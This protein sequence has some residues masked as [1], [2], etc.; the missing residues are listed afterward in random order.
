MKNQ[1]ELLLEYKEINHTTVDYDTNLGIIDFFHKQ[2]C[3]NSNEEALV[4]NKKRLTYKELDLC[5]NKVAHC[6]RKNGIQEG[7]SV[8]IILSDK[9][10]FVISLLGIVKLNASY[11]P[12]DVDYPVERIRFM[13]EDSKS[14]C[15]ICDQEILEKNLDFT[16]IKYDETKLEEDTKTYTKSCPDIGMDVMYTSGT[17]GKP[18]GVMLPQ[19]GTIR[20]CIQNNFYQFKEHDRLLG[21]N[22]VIFDVSV[23][24]IWSALLNGLTL[25]LTDKQEVLEVNR[26][27]EFLRENKINVMIMSTSLFTELVRQDA[28]AFQ[29][30]DT[31]L[32]AGDTL[33]PHT[34]KLLYEA[35]K[36]VQLLNG[37]GPTENST[38]STCYVVKRED[39]NSETIPIGVPISRS[40]I[41]V[42]DENNQLQERNVRGELCVGGVGVAKEYKNRP[43]LSDKKFMYLPFLEDTIYKT[44]DSAAIDAD[45]NVLFYGR[46]DNQVKIRGFRVEL[47][48]IRN[49]MLEHSCIENVIV[50][51]EMDATNNKIICAYYV[52]S[53]ILDPHILRGY[54]KEK[55]PIYSIPNYFYQLE[56]FPLKIN[57]K[58][59]TEQLKASK[60]QAINRRKTED[61]QELSDTEQVI[62]TIFKEIFSRE[63]LL[64]EDDFFL[65]GGNS[66][67]IGQII[68][69][70]RKSL[71]VEV[72]VSTFYNNS[73][74]RKLATYIDL[75]KQ[76][77]V[78]EAIGKYEKSE[79]YLLSPAQLRIYHAICQE[80]ESITYN[81]PYAF[82]LDGYLDI[83]CLKNAFF[84]M[85]K[86]HALLR[87]IILEEDGIPVQKVLGENEFEVNNI[88][89]NVVKA[90]KYDSKN[91]YQ[92]EFDNFISP[93][94]LNEGPLWRWKVIEFSNEKSLLLFDIHHIIFDGT[95][96]EIFFKELTSLY[97]ASENELKTL[98][99]DYFDY[100]CWTDTTRKSNSYQKLGEYWS[101]FFK[102]DISGF[103]IQ[104][105]NPLHRSN[106]KNTV[107]FRIPMSFV[108]LI[109]KEFMDKHITLYN[110][111][112]SC[113]GITL[114]K[115][116]ALNNFYIGSIASGRRMEEFSDVIGMFANT[117][118]YSVNINSELCIMDYMYQNRNQIMDM[119][120]NQ[121]YTLND[122]MKLSEYG[123]VGNRSEFLQTV[124]VMENMQALEPNFNNLKARRLD[125]SSKKAKFDLLF[126][127]DS[128]PDGV[129]FHIEYR[130]GIVQDETIK[131]LAK[132][133]QT[134]L[135]NAITCKDSPI[136][137]F[138]IIE[139]EEKKK[140][141]EVY[142][143]TKKDYG[144]EST[145]HE[146]FK[147]EVKE[148]TDLSALVYQGEKIS[149][150]E[151]DE[152]T[153]RLASRLL[154]MGVYTGEVV[155]LYLDG[156]VEQIVSILAVL[157]AGA[158][159]MPIDI[160][161][162]EKWI[163]D[164][165]NDS[166][167]RFV[168]TEEKYK[169]DKKI[170]GCQCIVEDDGK[171]HPIR[172]LER[173]NG[174]ASAYLMYTSGT[175]GVPKGVIVK[176]KNVLRLVKNTDFM[177]FRKE[178]RF[179]QTSSVVFDAST[180]EIWGSLLNGMTLYLTDKEEIL[181]INCI[182]K[183][184]QEDKI[185]ALWLSAPLFNQLSIDN[186]DMFYGIS[187][188]L[189]GGDVLPA[190]QI[191]RVRETNP[192]LHI[193][194][195][196]GP[197]ENT[198]FSATFDIDGN[199]E[200][201][202]IGYPITNSTLYIMDE[203]YHLL[204]IGATGEICVGGEG[205]AH[206]YLHD[207]ELT[208]KKFINDPYEEGGK[209]YCTGDLGRWN[210]K[211]YVE[212]LGR[213]DNQ[214]KIR[215]FRV[216][217]DEIKKIMLEHP[218]MKNVVVTIEKD[219]SDNKVICAY[220]IAD[221]VLE[222]NT[223][224]TFLKEKLPIYSVPN[225]FYQMESFPLKVTGKV[226]T[227]LLIQSKDKLINKRKIED[228]KVATETEQIILNM[229]KEIFNR[230][231][232]SVDDNFFLEGGNSLQ[233]GQIIARIRKE[234]NVE[235][236]V[237][238]FYSHSV[239]KELASYVDS[240][241]ESVT[242][243]IIKKH[244]KEDRYPL[245]AAQLRIYHSCCLD[246]NSNIYNIPYAFLLDGCVDVKRLKSAFSKMVKRHA[247][248]R[249][250]II[251]ENGEPLQQ[252]LSEKQFDEENIYV[253]IV[254]AGK[255]SK[256]QTLPCY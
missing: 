26:I 82:L 115:F 113:L 210:E 32:V 228:Y 214:T 139:K 172:T 248:L 50:T 200:S 45:G 101:R 124:F 80:E 54:L 226:D 81:I 240:H 177:E 137:D 191:N 61:N 90:G 160:S 41:Y 49:M 186:E 256:D 129:I 30:L 254:K 102:N 190:T 215:G 15:A 239:I 35:C 187:W 13:L 120:D 22:N 163:E 108:D 147:K 194:N 109:N 155:A 158:I 67:Q 154:D 112:V 39:V 5:S 221:G 94:V 95:S 121:D 103:Q 92:S 225:Y 165:V 142:N 140:I 84:H 246:K 164:M 159:Y 181:D 8:A 14:K 243:S 212:F 89:I 245:S 59:D 223:L 203:G 57:G 44:G 31:I 105:K 244:K 242:G 97:N 250:K 64:V 88:A 9:M 38:L 79:R 117:I 247:I 128:D 114:S 37:Y 125:I 131:Q 28:K 99:H 227:E 198:T 251:K 255:Y 183:Y 218:N 123:T 213:K 96:Q 58:I 122:I 185:D 51:V 60:E 197:T 188:L 86:R 237:H 189:V 98:E 232:L 63:D 201:I 72:S 233:I 19:K 241:K 46:T 199:Y 217:I 175:T 29:T 126:I 193:V 111:I 153:D 36:K 25:Y 156:K 100:I 236:S 27:G 206:G 253:N 20:L 229:Y 12:I 7:D 148:H 230:D 34:V 174:E 178:G 202:P 179:L 234:L 249:T 43:E 73:K 141:I 6:L 166:Q 152:R 24:E 134:V 16:Y 75:H 150:C 180:L 138:E 207:K 104:G 76:G 151:L 216:E 235:V 211:G 144:K 85:L 47:D 130:K 127:C 48:E 224:R 107:S 173:L 161:Y 91:D 2:V 136:K 17:T 196:Y 10:D 21:T 176:H 71:N 56:K 3:K 133:L 204:P 182:R 252:V 168:I 118:L 87:I 11:V 93:F 208:E 184:I 68:A 231:D 238:V 119:L 169:E 53:E 74:I 192:K 18:K 205:V 220:Y 52:A 146:L 4:Y 143:N 195:G 40:S 110:Y 83:N 77:E 106:E 65:E 145:I 62:L 42:L 219:V 116:T 209:L 70:I 66:L 23:Q 78:N 167:A 222:T 55:L 135:F 1:N 157:K 33:F 132:A 149:Y 162:P 171:Q 69:K 170:K